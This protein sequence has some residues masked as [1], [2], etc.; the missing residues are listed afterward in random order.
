MKNAPMRFDGL[1]LHHNPHK[2][3]IENRHH[4]RSLV[5]P[6]ADPDS[7]YLNRNPCV[8]SGEGELYGADCISQYREL[9]RLYRSKKR[10]K[11]VLPQMPAI[12]AYL[13]ELRLL[14]E[15]V[16]D[17]ISYYFVFVEAQSPRAHQPSSAWYTVEESG[18]SLW[19]VGYRFGVMIDKL[20]SLNPQIPHVDELVKGERV[21]LC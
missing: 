11:L 17:V 2:L 5:S 1:S 6:A 12:Y 4:I 16:E 20:V 15:P 8:V 10:A 9:E 21:R 7:M 18:E 3:S 14:S 19:D 13:R